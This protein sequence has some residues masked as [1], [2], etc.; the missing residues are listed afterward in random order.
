M[1]PT[2]KQ[3]VFSAL[4]VAKVCGVVN[5]T[6]INWIRAGK[7]KAS[8]TPG[9]QFRVYPEDLRGFLLENGMKIPDDLKEL[10]RQQRASIL[11]VEDDRVLNDLLAVQLRRQW[12]EAD[13]F[14]AFD[15]FEAGSLLGV[16]RPEVVLLDLNLPGVDGFELCRRIKQEPGFEQPWVVAMT[17]SD[18]PGLE[19]RLAAL[20][21]DA[22]FRK[23]FDFEL[24]AESLHKRLSR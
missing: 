3:K 20:G 7:L 2:P 6:V 8:T 12:P 17:S 11:V 4:E 15:G 24:L 18:E 1:P 23:P 13:L 21:A 5:Q 19:D 16:N 22:F 9:G 14:Q 10:F